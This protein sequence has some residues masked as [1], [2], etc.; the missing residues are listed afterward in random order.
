LNFSQKNI[1]VLTDG[2]DGMLSQVIGLA[3]ELSPNIK[4]IKTKILFPWSSLQPGIIPA[5]SWSFNND[6]NFISNI[7]IVISCGRKSVYLSIFLKKKYE[8]LITIHIQD[9]KVNFNK[10]NYIV[11]PEHDNIKGHNVIN[12]IGA[13]HKFDKNFLDSV[14]DK[15]FKIPKKNLMSIIIGGTNNHYKFSIKEVN[16]LVAK[17]LYF[18][19]INPNLNYLIIFSRRTT[20]EIKISIKNKLH[21]D[22]MVWYQN[23]YNPY[24]FA[25]KYSDYFIVTS[26][27]T[28]MISECAFTGKPIYIFH[29]P[30]KRISKR[31]EKFHNQFQ[32]LN[33]T[34]DLNSTCELLSWIYK[35]LNESKRI[36]SIIKER[37]IKEWK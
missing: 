9:P 30:Y 37:I 26:D 19:K 24:T 13:L 25:L 20:N 15:N 32:I 4:S 22:K 18:K 23:D 5:Y 12:S 3:Q 11:A 33:I 1:L 27:S 7:D 21:N 28:S 36:A 17:I 10:F 31:I 34:K 8:N 14:L 6:L 2:S 16:N 35:P 29:L